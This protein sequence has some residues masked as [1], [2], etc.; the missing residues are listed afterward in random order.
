MLKEKKN[1]PRI[2]DPMKIFFKYEDQI[3]IVPDSWKVKRVV[4]IRAVLQEMLKVVLKAEGKQ[5]QMKLRSLE[6]NRVLEMVNM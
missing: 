5:H 2:L 6:R 4:A 3:K 1:Q